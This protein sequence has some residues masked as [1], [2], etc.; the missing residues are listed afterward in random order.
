MAIK[1][2]NRRSLLKESDLVLEKIHINLIKE[3]EEEP[4]VAYY[5]PENLTRM[6]LYGIAITAPT[7]LLS[8]EISIISLLTFLLI[9]KDFIKNYREESKIRDMINAK[10]LNNDPKLKKMLE[11]LLS[12]LEKSKD[13][14]NVINTINSMKNEYLKN[15]ENLRDIYRTINT[16]WY[17]SK[18]PDDLVPPEKVNDVNLA[19]TKIKDSYEKYQNEIRKQ[20]FDIARKILSSEKYSLLRTINTKSGQKISG[21]KVPSRYS[22]LRR[23]VKQVEE[24]FL[25]KIDPGSIKDLKITMLP[26][27]DAVYGKSNVGG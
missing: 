20:V 14:N 22:Y 1:I 24:Y 10:Y 25:K 17:Q 7:A 13:V 21:E 8:P 3:N 9:N 5:T 27:S 15:Q 6:I 16:R 19:K 23:L 4:H 11:Q 2:S 12:D 26:K 18:N